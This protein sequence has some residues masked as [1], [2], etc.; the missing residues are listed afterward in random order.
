MREHKLSVDG[1]QDIT[2]TLYRYYH[3]SQKSKIL[4]NYQN[5][6]LLLS[7]MVGMSFLVQSCHLF[8]FR[9]PRVQTQYYY[10]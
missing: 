10:L 3:G 5:P 7:K 6:L 4:F 8:P 1:I 2:K 9:I